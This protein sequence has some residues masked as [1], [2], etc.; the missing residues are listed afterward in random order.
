MLPACQAA[1]PA[2]PAQRPPPAASAPVSPGC[3]ERSDAES[4]TPLE[5]QADLETDLSCRT[6]ARRAQ[7]ER[8]TVAAGPG[9]SLLLNVRDLPL[10]AA[11]VENGSHARITVLE[12]LRFTGVARIPRY[13]VATSF[14]DADGLLHL[15]PGAVATHLRP[16]G[17][18][19]IATFLLALE[20]PEVMGV[21]IPC[22]AL[23]VPDSAFRQ[24]SVVVPERAVLFDDADETMG[25]WS[26][27]GHGKQLM[28]NAGANGFEKLAE[29]GSFSQLR[30]RTESGSWLTGWVETARL[31]PQ[32][33]GNLLGEAF[34]PCG[35][36]LRGIPE[37]DEGDVLGWAEVPVGVQVS[38]APGSVPWAEVSKPLRATAVQRKRLKVIQLLEI[39][40][41][42]GDQGNFLDHAMVSPEAVTFH[43]GRP[44]APP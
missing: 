22:D 23:A 32:V 38:A 25:L 1:P 44:P 13:V 19:A 10:T 20:G 21:Q 15:E 29:V 30:L 9:L 35:E 31:S 6:S 42:R 3:G 27:P 39:A 40:G 34:A 4:T 12:P 8:L 41:L 37:G 11:P 36:G 14:D 18:V 24:K 43:P 16:L 26:E 28:V 7:V 2:K 17:E 5:P 33:W